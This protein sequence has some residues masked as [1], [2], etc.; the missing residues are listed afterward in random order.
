MG[1]DLIFLF[2]LEPLHHKFKIDLPCLWV[3][4]TN[5]A[6]KNNVSVYRNLM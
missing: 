1:S 3:Y 4:T 2:K 5:L 6:I